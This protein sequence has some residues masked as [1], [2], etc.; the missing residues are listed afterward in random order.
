MPPD[1]YIQKA[2]GDSVENAT[3]NDIKVAIQETIAMDDEHGAFWVGFNDEYEII[4][5][6]H[7]NLTVYGMFDEDS[8]L[9]L[10]AQMDSWS[11]I[12]QLYEIFLTKDFEKLKPI[13]KSKKIE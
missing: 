2:W 8:D 7:K 13:F 5:E 10:R 6:S 12:E 11:E 3:F 4:L 1:I 9:Q